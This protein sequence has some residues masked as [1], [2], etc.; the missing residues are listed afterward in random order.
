[1]KP[2]YNIYKPLNKEN[3]GAALQFSYDERKRAVFLEAARQKGARMEIGNKEQFDWQAKL[4]FKIGTND[5]GQLLLLIVGKTTEAKLI[6]KPENGNHVAVLEIKKQTGT[7]DNYALKLSRTVKNADGKNE[8]RS[9]SIF[10]D[11]HE[12]AI[13][14]HF[15]R[16]ALTG[17]LGFDDFMEE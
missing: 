14:S 6:H 10:I 16:E 12:M 7:Y 11:H 3:A 9:I 17:I 4:V 2:K 13:L 1:M 5:I 15:F 8:T